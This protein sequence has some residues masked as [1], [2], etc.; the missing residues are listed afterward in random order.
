MNYK[1]IEI[2]EVSITARIEGMKSGKHRHFCSGCQILWEHTGAEVNDR[3]KAHSCPNCGEYITEIFLNVSKL[4]PVEWDGTQ[5]N[6]KAK[7]SELKRQ[8]EFEISK[9]RR[10]YFRVYWLSNRN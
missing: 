2:D 1:G 7:L 9:I 3:H 4:I 5:E 6:S 10:I 8:D